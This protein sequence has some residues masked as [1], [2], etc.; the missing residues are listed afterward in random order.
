MRGNRWQYDDLVSIPSSGQGL[1]GHPSAC[2]VGSR[3]GSQY[4]LQGRASSDTAGSSV[5]ES[6]S[7]VSIPSSGQGLFGQAWINGDCY[8]QMCLNTLFRAGP[9]RT[10]RNSRVHPAGSGL[11]TLFRAGPLRTQ[12]WTYGTPSSPSS[13]YPLQGRASSD[14]AQVVRVRSPN[15]VSI[16]SSG[17]GLFGRMGSGRLDRS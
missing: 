11:N 14:L 13:Q 15:R 7:E 4:P 1:F 12:R 17:Q 3:A 6:Q 2:G 5:A 9:L 16:P 8:V 10:E